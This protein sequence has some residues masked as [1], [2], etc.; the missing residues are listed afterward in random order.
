MR[1]KETPEE[2]A[3]RR[4]AAGL[5]RRD[6]AH[7][8]AR[9]AVRGLDGQARLRHRLAAPPARRRLRGHRLAG[10]VRRPRRHAV[11]GADLPRGD[12]A[13][14]RP[15]RGL[16]LR[17]DPAR[18]PDHRRRGHARAA[19][20]VPAAD[21]AGRQRVVPGLLRA[22]GRVRPGLAAHPGGPRRRPLRRHG[23]EDL[24]VARPGGRLLRAAGPHRPRGAQAPGHHV[25]DHADGLARHHRA[26]D[27]DA[28]RRAASSARCSSTR[29]ASPSR[30]GSAPRTTAG[31]SPW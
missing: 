4:R 18:R 11:R 26:A 25:A 23:P 24:D 29:C 15:L 3:F 27:A 31:G 22:R 1:L 16:Q 20:A 8:A 30:T 13:G 28:H 14:R 2:Q 9:A 5:A 12:R 10:R 6:A 19:G 21:P 7:A 17:V